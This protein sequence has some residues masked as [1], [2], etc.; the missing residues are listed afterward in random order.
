MCFNN[1]TLCVIIITVIFCYNSYHSGIDNNNYCL[2]KYYECKLSLDTAGFQH[3]NIL[4]GGV[5]TPVIIMW[6]EG[7]GVIIMAPPTQI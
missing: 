3:N 7:E 1:K 6:V 5:G 2:A 4:L